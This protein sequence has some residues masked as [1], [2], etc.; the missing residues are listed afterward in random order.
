V[1]GDPTQ[2]KIALVFTADEYGEGSGFILK[3]L[4]EQEVKGAF[5]L[6]GNYLRNP[7]HSSAVKQ[8]ITDG[9]YIGPHSDQHLL[10]C[11]WDNRDSVLV[12]RSQFRED[13]TANYRELERRGISAR[14][15]SLFMPPFEWY[16]RT[17]AEWAGAMGVQ[18]VNFTPGLRTPADYTYPQMGARYLPSQAIYRQVLD[19]EEK[20]PGGLNGFILLVHAGTDPRREDKFYH[21][22]PE[23]I[24]AL[25]ARGYEFE[26]L[27]QL[28][29]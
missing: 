23:L 24:T 27:D 13:L 10:Y 25:K 5:F 17:V 11:D 1:R 15:A 12:S 3:A 7:L 14:T 2:R 26:R 21:M 19:Y 8:M 16:N 18:L 20:H 6:T 9:H 4:K 22:L 29:Q 28:V